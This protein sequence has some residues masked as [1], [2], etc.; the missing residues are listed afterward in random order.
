MTY[1]ASDI[2]GEYKKYIQMLNKINFSDSDI[3]YVLGDVIDRGSEPKKSWK[4]CQCD[5]TYVP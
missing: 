3:L 5:I 1:V 4:T 2:H